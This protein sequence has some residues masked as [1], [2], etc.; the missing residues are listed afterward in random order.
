[1]CCVTKGAFRIKISSLCGERFM[2]ASQC[3]KIETTN[4]LV[5]TVSRTHSHTCVGLHK[6]TH[7]DTHT[8]THTCFTSMQKD[9]CIAL[10]TPGLIRTCKLILALTPKLKKTH[11]LNLMGQNFVHT[12]ILQSKGKDIQGLDTKKLTKYSAHSHSCR[13]PPKYQ[14][15][16]ATALCHLWTKWLQHNSYKCQKQKMKMLSIIW[17]LYRGPE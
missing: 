14:G 9:V 17:P 4:I 11:S 3:E 12:S 16:L 6:H 15:Y 2:Q 13:I 10:S 7:T 8:H 1:M 5:W